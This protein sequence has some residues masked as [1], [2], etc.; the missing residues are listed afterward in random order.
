MNEYAHELAKQIDT[1]RTF[2]LVGVSLGGMLA[3]E[4][5][6]FLHPKK[7]ILISSAKN[8]KELPGGYRFQKTIPFYKLISGN[9]SKKGALFFQP[10]FEPDRNYDKETFISMLTDKDPD[11]LKRTIAMIIEWEKREGIYDNIIHIH[12]ES[13]NTIPIRN[14]EYD[15]M[16]KE[17]SHMMI[18]TRG[19]EISILI[20]KILLES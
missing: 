17:G 13:D 7:I 8:R 9:L 4:I 14:V 20:N 18:L 11:F 5:G 10:I 16:I 1:T 12:G 2:Y 6:E 15:Y 3:T 19:K